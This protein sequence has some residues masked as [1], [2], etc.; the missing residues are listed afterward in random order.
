MTEVVDVGLVGLIA[1]VLIGLTV[2]SVVADRQ[3]HSDMIA[4]GL[5]GYCQQNGEFAFN[6]ECGE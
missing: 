5:A 4:R 1:G 3:W 2:G 6:G